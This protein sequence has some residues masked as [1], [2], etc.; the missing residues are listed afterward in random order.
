MFANKHIP[1]LPPTRIP[2]RGLPHVLGSFIPYHLGIIC[3][4]LMF[5]TVCIEKLGCSIFCL[6]KTGSRKVEGFVHGC[7]EL[8]GKQGLKPNATWAHTGPTCKATPWT[9]TA[10]LWI[11]ACSEGVAA[12]GQDHQCSGQTKWGRGSLVAVWPRASQASVPSSIKQ[13]EHPLQQVVRTQ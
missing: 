9:K 10:A 7:W 1:L 6:I 5:H 11:W 4:W 12:V 13:G 8:K 2:H 3:K